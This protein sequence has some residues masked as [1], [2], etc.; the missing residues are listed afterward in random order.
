MLTLVK[1]ALIAVQRSQNVQSI[2]RKLKSCTSV[3]F[4]ALEKTELS[5]VKRREL[6]PVSHGEIH[7]SKFLKHI[8]YAA[9]ENTQ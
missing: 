6:A 2:L 8:R 3:R 4:G 1:L 7:P 9:L 5:A